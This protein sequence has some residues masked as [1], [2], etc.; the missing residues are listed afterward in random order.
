MQQKPSRRSSRRET[1]DGQ[2]HQNHRAHRHHYLRRKRQM[3]D[4]IEE[5]LAE[6]AVA[7][8]KRRI[9]MNTLRADQLLIAVAK[10]DTAMADV[11]RL[12]D[13]EHRLVESYRSKELA[14]LDKKRSWLVWNLE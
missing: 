8:E 7:D 13:D 10:L 14:R 4:F 11:N 6:S 3:T 2:H 1:D 9:E 12:A 5:L